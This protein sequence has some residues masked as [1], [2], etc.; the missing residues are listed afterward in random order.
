MTR[1]LLVYDGSKRAFRAA[2]AALACRTDLVPVPWES[3]AVGAFLEAQFGGRPFAFVLVEGDDVH[4][5]SGTVERLLRR[6]GVRP[7][8][9]AALAGAYPHVAGPFG[10][11]AHGREPADLDGT[12][13][14][15][16]EARAHVA[17]LRE[18]HEVPVEEA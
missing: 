2:A 18:G 3:E 11:V 7:S 6:R 5:G 8:V 14:L 9:A 4:V 17:S 16:P 13:P 1:S 12:F 10:R 15:D